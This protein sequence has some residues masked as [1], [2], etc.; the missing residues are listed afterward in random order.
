LTDQVC[1]L[2]TE[3]DKFRCRR[4]ISMWVKGNVL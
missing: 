3:Q 2:D 1:L 4:A